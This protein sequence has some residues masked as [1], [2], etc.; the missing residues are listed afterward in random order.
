MKIVHDLHGTQIDRILILELVLLVAGDERKMVDVLVQL[1]ERKFDRLDAE[2]VE[3][4]KLLLLLRLQIMQRDPGKVADDDVARDFV[5]SAIANKVVDVAKRLRLGLAQVL[6]ATLVLDQ[7][8]AGPEK[9]DVAVLAGDLL[10]RLLKRRHDAAAN[11]EHREKL[12]PKRLFLGALAA[13]AGPVA[14]ESDGVVA[15]FVPGNGHGGRPQSGPTSPF[16]PPV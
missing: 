2:L 7:Q 5:L 13:G 14:G 15:N 16:R 3:Q 9:V 6:P 8:H 1:V 12:V 4:R 10:H 11:A